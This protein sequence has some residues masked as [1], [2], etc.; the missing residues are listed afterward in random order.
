MFQLFAQR[1]CQASKDFPDK[2]KD[3]EKLITLRLPQ[4][5]YEYKLLNLLGNSSFYLFSMP[6][7]ITKLTKDIRTFLNSMDSYSF[8]YVYYII[9]LDY[10][11]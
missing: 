4:Q 9:I 5:E 3:L 2:L 1:L 10:I 6:R 11:F 8:S 7:L